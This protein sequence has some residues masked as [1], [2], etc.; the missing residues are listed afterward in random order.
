MLTLKH[1]SFATSSVF[2]TSPFLAVVVSTYILIFH[3]FFANGSQ[4]FRTQ[5]FLQGWFP[6][7]KKIPPPPLKSPPSEFEKIVSPAFYP[8]PS[9]IAKIALP[10]L[11]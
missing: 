3:H 1:I 4:L 8:S 5:S 7:E 9:K 6:P 2:A 11:F 10:P